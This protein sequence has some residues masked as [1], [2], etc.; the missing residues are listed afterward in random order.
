M[1][2]VRHRDLKDMPEIRIFYC[3]HCQYATLMQE[4]A[5]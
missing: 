3:S 1:G 2:L 4:R 5:A